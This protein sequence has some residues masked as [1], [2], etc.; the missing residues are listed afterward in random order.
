MIGIF[1]AAN[2]VGCR[3]MCS[4]PVANRPEDGNS[5]RSVQVN[6]RDQPIA[7]ATARFLCD[8]QA[9]W[10]ADVAVIGI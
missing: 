1:N 9:E 2:H 10:S 3:V 5:Q 4:V 8:Q 7:A 6:Q